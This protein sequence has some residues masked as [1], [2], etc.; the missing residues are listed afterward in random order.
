MIKKNAQ[1]LPKAVQL[2]EMLIREIMAGRL[3]D[4]ARLPPERQMA[5]TYGVAVGTVRKALTKLQ[6]QGLLDRVQGSG[7]YV[8]VHTCVDSIYAFFRLERLC[9]A[10]LPTAK[11]LDVLRLRKPE[12][13]PDF[14]TSF[15]AHRIRR[16][17]YLDGELVALEEIWLDER[18]A[19]RLTARDLGDS[20]YHYYKNALGLVIARIEDKISIGKTPDWTISDFGL[21]V[22]DPTGYVERLSWG[23]DD[24]AAEYSRTWFHPARARYISRLQ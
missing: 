23:Q 22:G 7:N 4:G 24:Q 19:D 17:R 12:D 11:V 21:R 6:D 1:A 9:G 3:V 8:R 2:S 13:A 15:M 5:A 14:G 20:L 10:G 18:F 16:L